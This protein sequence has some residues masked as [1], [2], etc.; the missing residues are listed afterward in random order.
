LVEYQPEE[1]VILAH[2]RNYRLWRLAKIK[3]RCF[4]W[5]SET[6]LTKRDNRSTAGEQESVAMAR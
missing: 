3:K 1:I 4:I 2:A 5:D 6:Q